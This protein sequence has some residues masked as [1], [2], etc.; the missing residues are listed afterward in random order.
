MFG[1]GLGNYS[2]TGAIAPPQEGMSKNTKHVP[3]L[4]FRN[5]KPSGFQLE[6]FSFDLLL[7]K[8]KPDKLV[9]LVTALLLERKIV[10]IKDEIGDIALI[11]QGLL[12]LLNPF[13][14]CFTIITYLNR[15]LVD[16][17]DA[18]FPFVIG[19]STS[20]WEDICTLKDYPEDIYIFDLESQERRFISKVE[21][22][23]L[24]YPY[25]DDLLN[26][27]KDV[28]DKKDR[29]LEA[30]KAEMKQNR[31]TRLNKQN[32]DQFFDEQYWADAELS[33][34]QLFFNFLLMTV[35][36]Y[37]QFYVIADEAEIDKTGPL[38]GLKAS[39]DVFNFQ[40]YLEW[41]EERAA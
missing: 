21:I 11:M 20:T 37:K 26:G 31:S 3:L 39:E 1:Q 16:M 28:M 2:S 7:Q 4:K 10:L 24:P 25:G 15:D 36:N 30:L 18:P 35:N 14:W 41:Q 22:P 23:E 34:K 12:T 6:N 13:Q 19:V 40:G 33:V 27:L 32:L 38:A 17:L 8:L 29:R 9:Y 5:L